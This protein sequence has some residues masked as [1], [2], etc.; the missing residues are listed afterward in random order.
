V[1]AMLGS[2]SRPRF[3]V[4]HWIVVAM[5]L[6]ATL[7]MLPRVAVM[8]GH[9]LGDD[10]TRTLHEYVTYSHGVS[11]LGDWVCSLPWTTG[12]HAAGAHE[13]NYPV[14]PLLLF[15]LLLWPRGA[16]TAVL[17][18]AALCLTFA[19]LLACNIAPISSALLDVVPILKA[20]RVPARAVMPALTIVPPLALAA[21]WSRVPAPD[22]R[23]STILWGAIAASMVIVL[24]ARGT[25]P[26]VREIASWSACGALATILRWFPS[27]AGSPLL[28]AGLAIVA[29]LGLLAFDDRLPQGVPYER[30]E[31]G[32]RQL[33]ETVH[34]AA[35]ELADSALERV[36][37]FEP[38]SVFAMSTAY[39]ARLPSLDGMWYPPRRFLA[40][41][42]ALSG[43]RLPATT[44]VFKFSRS[45]MFPILQQLYNVRLAVF[46]FGTDEPSL[47]RLP[48]TP[49][50]AWFPR[51][52][53]VVGGEQAVADALRSSEDLRTTLLA[54]AWLAADD[55]LLSPAAVLGCRDARVLRVT[56]DRLGQ[57]A[58]IDVHVPT[59]CLLV[60]ATN[61][62]RGLRAYVVT[63]DRRAETAIVPVN[64]ALTGIVVP[65]GAATVLLGPRAVVTVW[66]RVGQICGI[67]LLLL[68]LVATERL[69]ARARR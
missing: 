32:P 23:R 64:I 49:G 68:A 61:F 25:T 18:S 47:R 51:R 2:P 43:E 36:Q 67:V 3:N 4:A 46:G 62:V 30:I 56:T 16:S 42:S 24:V 33:R 40:L 28:L 53:H 48:E 66:S 37:I 13:R 60:V 19:I 54:E 38:R 11:Q 50:A 31:D 26:W 15:L 39:A 44:A 63:D 35:P 7:T 58:T 14:G 57:T 6:A 21:W 20:F 1:A 17:W 41:L 8:I 34:S 69:S 55:L 59:S 9:A 65:A 45:G 27:R 29:A 52:V 22:R 10:A 12:D 5:V